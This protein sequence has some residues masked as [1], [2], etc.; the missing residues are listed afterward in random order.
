MAPEV[1]LG[2]PY[3]KSVDVYSFGVIFW[4]ILSGS[5]P[6]KSMSKKGYMEKVVV[7][8]QRPKVDVNWSPRLKTL[9]ESCW[10]EDKNQRPDFSVILDELNALIQ[11]EDEVD[12]KFGL[13]QLLLRCYY[14]WS[15]CSKAFVRIRLF[16]LLI[17]SIFFIVSVCLLEYGNHHR[18]LDSIIVAGTTLCIISSSGMYA[19]FMIQLRGSSLS[20]SNPK[21]LS[22]R[23]VIL[24]LELS[25]KRSRSTEEEALY[26][27]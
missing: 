14:Y 22:S 23:N 27:L 1:A 13:K 24:G 9:L 4:Q 15:L 11:E 21:V 8:G 3:N 25:S 26:G 12:A 2:R 16:V 20:L 10:L 5:M 19:I 18:H 6:F 17:A 7:G